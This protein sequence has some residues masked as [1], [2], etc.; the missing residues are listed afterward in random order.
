V[1]EGTAEEQGKHF[2]VALKVICDV[3]YGLAV[4]R[5]HF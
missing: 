5:L 2:R 3:L 1:G 4:M